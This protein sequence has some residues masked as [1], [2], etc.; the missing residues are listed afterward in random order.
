MLLYVKRA[1]KILAN[2]LT[3]IPSR[4]HPNGLKKISPSLVI[5][6][7]ESIKIHW[8]FPPIMNEEKIN[9]ILTYLK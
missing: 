3:I 2:Y 4:Q 1:F 5:I 8:K 6:I 7:R 9:Q